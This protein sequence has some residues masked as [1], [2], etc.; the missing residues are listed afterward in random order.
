MTDTHSLIWADGQ[1][2]SAARAFL[3]AGERA[4]RYGDGVFVTLHLEEGTLLDAAAQVGRL[5]DGAEVLGLHVPPALRAPE[6]LAGILR[7]LGAPRQGSRIVRVQLSARAGERGYVRVSDAAW[8]LVELIDP[9]ERRRLRVVCLSDGAVPPATLPRIKSCS[10]LPHVLAARAAAAR[11]AHEA[12]RVVGGLL[13]EAAA[14][15]LFWFRNGVLHTPTEDLPLYPGVTRGVV[16]RAARRLG[17]EVREG[18][19]RPDDLSG[20]AGVFLTN[21][22]RGLEPVRELDGRRLPWPDAGADLRDAVR[23]A[24]RAAGYPI[25]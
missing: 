16:V 22:V 12:L 21:A 25:G 7:E 11:G 24:R 4:F 13:T 6:G 1:V 10:A 14:A 9:P 18:R 19:Y 8:G 15:N 2:V 5:G 3:A 23:E 20:V 17:L